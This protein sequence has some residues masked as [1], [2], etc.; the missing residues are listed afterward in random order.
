MNHF[1]SRHFRAKHFVTIALLVA[2]F[3]PITPTGGG[4]YLAPRRRRQ[5][6]E[7]RDYLHEQILRED[8]E[9]LLLLRAMIT[10]RII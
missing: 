5:R 8:Q 1:A 9:I 4:T 2:I 7:Q 6:I 10:A 3:P